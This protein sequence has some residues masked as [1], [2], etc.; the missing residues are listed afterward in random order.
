MKP[1]WQRLKRL[2]FKWF[3]SIVLTFMFIV[4]SYFLG[5]FV[6]ISISFIFTV[7]FIIYRLF[8]RPS[9]KQ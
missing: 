1:R 7:L 4:P 6:G 8:T 3:D 5:F 2:R 9:N